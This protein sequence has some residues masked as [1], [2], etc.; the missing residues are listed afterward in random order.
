VRLVVLDPHL[1]GAGGQGPHDVGGEA[2]GYHRDAVG[3]TGDLDAD[4]DREIE[5]GTGELEAVAGELGLHAGQNRQRA[6]PGGHGPP[7][8]G[9]GFDE[10]VALTSELHGVLAFWS[11]EGSIEEVFKW[12][13]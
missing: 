12:W 13:S 1:H 7:G 10:T 6:A 8:G 3:F 9:Q 5:V 2:A 11:G 4:R